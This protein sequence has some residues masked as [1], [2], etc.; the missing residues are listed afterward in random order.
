[1]F[2][3]IDKT[4]RGRRRTYFTPLHRTYAV[5]DDDGTIIEGLTGADINAIEELGFPAFEIT[6]KEN[7]RKKWGLQHPWQFLRFPISEY[8]HYYITKDRRYINFKKYNIKELANLGF[9]YE[10]YEKMILDLI[11]FFKKLIK[12]NPDLDPTEWKKSIS[13]IKNDLRSINLNELA[14]KI[15]KL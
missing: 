15:D 13:K 3:D 6:S 2:R 4:L 12:N 14:K 11:S 10:F 8:Y 1:M 5:K 7:L 9:T